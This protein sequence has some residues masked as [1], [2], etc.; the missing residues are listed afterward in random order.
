M[1]YTWGGATRMHAV[2]LHQIFVIFVSGGTATA[3]AG[4][5]CMKNSW[6]T[7]ST[8]RSHS[9]SQNPANERDASTLV[10]HFNYEFN[11]LLIKPLKCLS[12]FSAATFRLLLLL[13]CNWHAL[14]STSK[15]QHFMFLDYCLLKLF[16]EQYYNIIAFIFARSSVGNPVDK[17]I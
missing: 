1:G 5:C 6:I 3:L 9:Q 14:R 4:N 17:S 15:S 11:L 10:K 13:L 7:T 16:H 8:K 2:W 12:T